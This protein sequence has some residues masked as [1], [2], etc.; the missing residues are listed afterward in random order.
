MDA[1]MGKWHALVSAEKEVARCRAEVN[2]L[3]SRAEILAEAMSGRSVWGRSTAMTFLRHFPE[4]VPR[5]L[6]LLVDLSLSIGWAQ[7][8][9][10]AILPARREIDLSRFT[11]I[12]LRHL[13]DGD[14]EDYL[15]L[16]DMLTHVEAW[17]ILGVVI[18]RARESDDPEIRQ[19]ADDFTESYG[20]MLP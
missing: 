5:F 7:Q 12:V 10:E 14:A 3:P 11:E 20:G 4:D 6:E 15:R 9:W 13:S 8:A 19:V 18:E 1:E 2:E 17:E 16:A